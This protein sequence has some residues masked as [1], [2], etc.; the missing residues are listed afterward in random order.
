MA[1]LRTSFTRRSL[2][3]LAATALLAGA[4]NAQSYPDRPVTIV[5]AFAPGGNVDATARAIG[6]ALSKALG[7]PVAEPSA[8]RWWRAPSPTATR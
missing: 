6:P 8:A 5:V 1:F 2:T 7:Q 3:V 4:A